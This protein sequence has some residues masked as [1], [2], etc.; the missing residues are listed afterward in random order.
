MEI[1]EEFAFICRDI[2]GIFP[3]GEK[4]GIKMYKIVYI[5]QNG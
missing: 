5:A 3:A 1:Q 2:F 4:C